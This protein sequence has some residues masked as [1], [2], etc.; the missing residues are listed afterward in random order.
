MLYGKLV[1]LLYIIIRYFHFCHFFNTKTLIYTSNV[2]EN[3]NL[4]ITFITLS[5]MEKEDIKMSSFVP[6]RL[7]WYSSM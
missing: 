6:Q 7:T 2:S 4:E 3:I 1:G 5:T